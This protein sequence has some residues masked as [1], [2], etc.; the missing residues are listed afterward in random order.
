MN[1]ESGR[2][3]P[4]EILKDVKAKVKCGATEEAERLSKE[5]QARQYGR[6]ERMWWSQH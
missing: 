1:L 5:G 3:L 4:W 6:M 2:R